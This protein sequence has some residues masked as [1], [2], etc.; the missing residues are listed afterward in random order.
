MRLSICCICLVV[1]LGAASL[2]V[3]QPVLPTLAGVRTSLT[4]RGADQAASELPVGFRPAAPAARGLYLTIN[5]ADA[6]DGSVR[7]AAGP[8]LAGFAAIRLF[9]GEGANWQSH[10]TLGVVAAST[11]YAMDDHTGADR[12]WRALAAGLLVGVAKEVSDGYFDRRDVEATACGAAVTVLMQ[13]IMPRLEW[14]W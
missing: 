3:A 14:E 12:C 5:L 2:A 6:A 13:A 9:D 1:M 11:A 10:Y 8:G 4:M 7:M